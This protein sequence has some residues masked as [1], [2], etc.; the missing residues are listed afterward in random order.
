MPIVDDVVLLFVDI[1]GGEVDTVVDVTP[2]GTPDDARG[3]PSGLGT[4]TIVLPPGDGVAGTAPELTPT[5]VPEVSNPTDKFLGTI[6]GVDPR[7]TGTPPRDDT[8]DT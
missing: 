8:I 1:R 5:L 3:G 7:A 4:P 6:Y 2:V